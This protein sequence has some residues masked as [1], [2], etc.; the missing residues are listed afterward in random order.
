M[1]SLRFSPYWVILI[2]V[3]FVAL[4]KK[5]FFLY[6]FELS[7][8]KFPW[9]MQGRELENILDKNI[10]CSFVSDQWIMD[11]INLQMCYIREQSL[12]AT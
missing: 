2:V 12:A 8:H 5:I 1:I 9:F 6:F 7:E 3:S 10:L 4:K 11:V